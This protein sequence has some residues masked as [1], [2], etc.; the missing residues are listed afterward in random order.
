MSGT[1]TNINYA[2]KTIPSNH[3]IKTATLSGVGQTD[4]MTLT[5]RTTKLHE[6]EFT[7][8]IEDVSSATGTFIVE[9]RIINDDGSFGLT[10]TIYS[11]AAVSDFPQVGRLTGKHQVRMRCSAYTSG[12]F[13]LH[14]QQ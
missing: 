8:D 12:S 7:A 6:H 3:N 10:K 14:M 5:K 1:D 9:A 13:I 11:S 4:W 2:L